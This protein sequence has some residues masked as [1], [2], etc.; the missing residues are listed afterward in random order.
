MTNEQDFIQR[1]LLSLGIET[2]FGQ[3]A[4]ALA[5]NR[6]ST[7]CIYSGEIVEHGFD[8]LLLVTSRAPDTALFDTLPAANITRIG[9]CLLPSSIADAVYSGYKFAREFGEDPQTL[10][11]RRERALL[12]PLTQTPNAGEGK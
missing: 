5:G 11:C 9:D 2:V 10:G 4:A 12:Q 3:V 6:F 7:R 1:R 8:N